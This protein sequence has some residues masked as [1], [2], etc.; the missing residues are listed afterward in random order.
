MAFTFKAILD[1]ISRRPVKRLDELLA[2]IAAAALDG[3][4]GNS[5]AIMA[6]F[7][8]GCREGAGSARR[9][10][11]ARLASCCRRGSRLAW[12][13]MSEPV[14]G[15]LP[16][17]LQD[18]ADALV[19]AQAA[20]ERDLRVLFRCGLHKARES[21]AGTPEQL[22]VLKQAGVVDA[23]GQGFVDLLE[24]IQA[25][26]EQ[27][28]LEPLDAETAALVSAEPEDASAL[29]DADLGAH[30]FCTECVI[31]G[32]ALDR[33]AIMRALESLDQSSL[34]VAG[35]ERRKP[36]ARRFL[37]RWCVLHDN[38][39]GLPGGRPRCPRLAV[40]S[41]SSGNRGHS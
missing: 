24:G 19:Q 31:E 4:R 25:W 35:A 9:L 1:T 10:D 21:L 16:T 32:K 37:R 17:V 22:P 15:T 34:V 29:V 12:S 30:R 14:A 6:Q 8:E 41:S 3:A 26:L 5:G 23:G 13:A 38:Y 7:F 18:F 40:R 2:Q 36:A 28:V 39:S 33:T 11:A 20:G 27:G